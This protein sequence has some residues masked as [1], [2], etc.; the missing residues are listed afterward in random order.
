MK[1]VSFLQKRLDSYACTDAAEEMNA[2][3]EMM[4]E[5]ILAAFARTDFFTKAAFHGG[6]QLRIFESVRRFSEDLDFSLVK[7]DLDF[8]LLPYL[9]KVAAE[10]DAIGVAMEVV[11]K[12]KTSVTVKKGFLKNDSLVKILVLKVTP[13][14]GR[15]RKLS[16]KVEVDANPPAGATYSV[17]QLLFPFPA[18]IRNFDRCSA[19]AGK[20]HAL[21]CREYV[22]GRDWFDFIWYVGAGAG[23]NQAYLSNA[24]N[25]LG[26]W[27]GKNVMTD[28]A[29]V[30][31]NLLE[32]ISCIDWK[33]ARRDVL[34]FVYA[35]DRSSLDLWS[36]EFFT[37][38]VEKTFIAD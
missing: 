36:R 2:I 14:N 25:Q 6:T 21:L 31:Q 17:G 35:A 38:L 37:D 26:P 8:E 27:A 9:E 4:Q 34:P 22:K 13:R 32:V 15:M 18:S 7:Q 11:D 30:R 16:I 5:M 28:G 24:L 3:R 20:I 10:L 29:W 33:D 1:D 23:L 19:F 12:S